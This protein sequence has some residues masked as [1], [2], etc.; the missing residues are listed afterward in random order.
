M[1]L[2]KYLF[3]LTLIGLAL[4]NDKPPTL[5]QEAAKKRNAQDR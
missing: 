5:G 1:W 3:V 4:A 2:I